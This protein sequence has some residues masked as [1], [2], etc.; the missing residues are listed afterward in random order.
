MNKLRMLVSVFASLLVTLPTSNAQSVTGQISGIVSDSTGAVVGGATVQLT[1]DVSQ[2]VL[3]YV[4]TSS[5]SFIFTGLAPGTYSLHIT[6]P[7][8]KSYAYTSFSD[9]PVAF[10]GVL[11][12][13]LVPGD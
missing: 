4:T 9:N 13:R 7:G 11:P 6:H 10:C 3:G 5:G 8:F 2:H 1:H 12:Y